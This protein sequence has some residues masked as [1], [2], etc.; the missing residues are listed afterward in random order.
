MGCAVVCVLLR[1]VKKIWAVCMGSKIKTVVT[2][3]GM[4][5][6]YTSGFIVEADKRKKSER[7]P[8]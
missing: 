8:K 3:G 6:I 1:F 4:H 7:S 2:I 5:S